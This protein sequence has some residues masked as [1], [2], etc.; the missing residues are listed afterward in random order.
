MRPLPSK[1]MAV[2][3]FALF[4]VLVAVCQRC[5]AT[6]VSSTNKC[7]LLRRR[8]RVFLDLISRPSHALYSR[9]PARQS[10]SLT[11]QTMSARRRNDCSQ[12]RLT[13]L[14]TLLATQSSESLLLCTAVLSS[15]A[16]L[17]PHTNFSFKHCTLFFTTPSRPIPRRRLH[18][19]GNQSTGEQG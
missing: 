1:K 5:S 18:V 6:S 17:L 16:L 10:V 9:S 13:S 3:T 15:S 12:M 19:T 11:D 2:H 14:A 4:L 8:G 7:T